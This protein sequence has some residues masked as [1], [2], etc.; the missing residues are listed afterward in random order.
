ML[1][2]NARKSSQGFTL[3]EILVIVAIVGILS[4][5]VAPSFF[6][7]LNKNKV[8]NALATVK[9]A[10]QESQREAIKRS[11]TCTVTLETANYKVTGTCL[12]TG[13]RDLCEKRDLV[14]GTCLQP[15]VSMSTPG[16]NTFTGGNQITYG[17]RGNTANGGTVLLS[18]TDTANQRCLVTSLGIGIMR[19]G[20]YSG[21]T[22]TTS[23]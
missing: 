8:N 11:T 16:S 13:T 19:T 15:K 14:S 18:R 6:A 10:L 9:G 17:F 7:L 5:I 1:L 21:T 20:T 4:A 12:V 2:L 22:C 23:Q 3:I